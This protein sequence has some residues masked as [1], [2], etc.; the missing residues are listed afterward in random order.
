[1]T[2]SH[3][4]VSTLCHVCLYRTN[5]I[6]YC[7]KCVTLHW[8]CLIIS[9]PRVMSVSTEP[10]KSCIAWSASRFIDS[11]FL[12]N[13]SKSSSLIC[14]RVLSIS[15]IFALTC[16][17][18]LVALMFSLC[19]LGQSPS[20]ENWDYKIQRKCESGH[21]S[22][23]PISGHVYKLM[24]KLIKRFHVKIIRLLEFHFI[25]FTLPRYTPAMKHKNTVTDIFQWKTL[26]TWR[27][28]WHWFFSPLFRGFSSL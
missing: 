1:M 26:V 12:S 9:V 7:P 10:I 24:H 5:K 20:L 4:N 13:S 18:V 25:I 21:H 8:L 28:N 11:V 23:L 16:C 27:K 6:L 15:R 3:N 22:I 2:L 17:T 14:L 19:R